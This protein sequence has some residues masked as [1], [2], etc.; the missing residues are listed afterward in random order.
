MTSGTPSQGSG[1]GLGTF[2]VFLIVALRSLATFVKDLDFM[3]GWKLRSYHSIASFAIYQIT[4]DICQ[5]SMSLG[6]L[7]KIG[8]HQVG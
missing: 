4:E 8:N 5:R 7:L 6:G 3:R 2:D 1:D